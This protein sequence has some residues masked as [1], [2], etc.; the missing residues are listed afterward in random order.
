MLEDITI[1]TGSTAVFES[2]GTKLESVTLESR[3]QARDEL[4]V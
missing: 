4:V 3:G 2:L 1:L